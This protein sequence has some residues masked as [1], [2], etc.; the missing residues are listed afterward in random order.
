MKH[1]VHHWTVARLTTGTQKYLIT[2]AWV[3]YY[4]TGSG[5]NWALCPS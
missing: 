2:K 4:Y 5:T 1:K 3:V